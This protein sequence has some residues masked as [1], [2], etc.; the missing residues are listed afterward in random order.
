[1]EKPEL[2]RRIDLTLTAGDL[3]LQELRVFRQCVVDGD[4][5]LER[6]ILNRLSDGLEAFERGFVAL[7]AAAEAP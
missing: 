2:L 4:N 3:C 6:T 5:A 1:M 7:T